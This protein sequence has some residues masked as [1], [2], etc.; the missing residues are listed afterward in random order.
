MFCVYLANII[1]PQIS[2][3]T[4]SKNVDKRWHFNKLCE[5]LLHLICH[6]IYFNYLIEIQR[7]RRRKMDKYKDYTKEELLEQIELLEKAIKVQHDTINR[8]LDAYILK[9]N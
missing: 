1:S 6:M 4:L 2:C 3:L 5:T 9:S 7:N 8:M